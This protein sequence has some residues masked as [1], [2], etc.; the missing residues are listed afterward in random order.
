MRLAAVDAGVIGA[1]HCLNK[2]GGRGRE[3]RRGA[4]IHNPGEREFELMRL[5]QRDLEYTRDDLNASCETLGRS[6]NECDI[7]GLNAT[8]IGNFFRDFPGRRPVGFKNKGSPACL[9]LVLQFL[10][11]RLLARESAAGAGAE[12]EKFRPALAMRKR[13]AG[14]LASQASRHRIG[15]VNAKLERPFR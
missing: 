8:V 12:R 6:K 7:F 1:P 4:G 2:I 9:I 13:P 11:Q 15:A 5:M 3:W 14:I 10:K